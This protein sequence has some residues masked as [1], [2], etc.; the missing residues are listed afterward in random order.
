MNA[1]CHPNASAN[2]GISTGVRIAPILGAVLIRPIATLRVRSGRYIVAALTPAGVETDSPA[3]STIRAATNC[4]TVPAS[5]CAM[6][7]MLHVA[8][9]MP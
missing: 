2:G 6:P 9:A 8:T 7:A 4:C 3:A 1:A 5:A